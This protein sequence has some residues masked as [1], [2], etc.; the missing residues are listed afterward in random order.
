[1]NSTNKLDHMADFILRHTPHSGVFQ[2]EIPELKLYRITSSSFIE[3]SSGTIQTSLIVKGHKATTIGQQVYKYGE[4]QGLVCG[5]ASPSEFQV[6]DASEDKP[7][8]ALSVNLD[9]Q[10]LMEY[11]RQFSF[12]PMK[13]QP[14]ETVFVIRADE[15][16]L[17]CFGML[18]QLLEKPKLLNMRAPLVLKLLHILLLDS[19]CGA[20]LRNLA[21]VGSE[22]Y[23]VLQSVNWIREHFADNCYVEDLARQA[24]MSLA[25]F[26]RHF[27]Q[28][29]GYSPLQ[30]RKKVRL[31]EGR[32]MLLSRTKN[33]TSTA[34]AVGYDNVSQFVKDYKDLFGE[35][36]LRHIKNNM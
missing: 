22:S 11:S 5:V 19:S 27:R 2:T 26:Y 7:F 21:S 23:A 20:A 15:D 10:T 16:L 33:V 28:A 31:L 6:F 18:L 12:S 4:G 1:M 36:P 34:A 13:S 35:P 17:N 3:R 14:C 9:L 25:T 32:K 29:T 24:N 30:F 8:L